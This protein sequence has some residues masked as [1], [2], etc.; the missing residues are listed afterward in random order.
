MSLT[1]GGWNALSQTAIRT[2]KT[3]Q[4]VRNV[5]ARM[6]KTS[7]D[8]KYEIAKVQIAQAIVMYKKTFGASPFVA[9]KAMGYEELP[10]REVFEAA[11][12]TED[13]I[14]P[15]RDALEKD[16]CITTGEYK[17]S[18]IMAMIA[19]KFNYPTK[20]PTIAESLATKAAIDV[21]VGN[22]FPGTAENPLE[23]TLV[24]HLLGAYL[25][26][27]MVSYLNANGETVSITFVSSFASRD[28][29]IAAIAHEKGHGWHAVILGDK[30]HGYS[31]SE[32]EQFAM[33]VEDSVA[34]ILGNTVSA[35]AP[36]FATAYG[37]YRQYVYGLVQAI[38]WD[39]LAKGTSVQDAIRA[40]KDAMAYYRID[41]GNGLIIDA[42]EFHNVGINIAI[43]AID[44]II[45]VVDSAI[46]QS[47]KKNGVAEVLVE[48]V[49]PAEALVTA[50]TV[51]EDAP[52]VEDEDELSLSDVMVKHFGPDWM[53][54]SEAKAM[55]VRA[56][57]A[58]NIAKRVEEL[59]DELK[60][61]RADEEA[62]STSE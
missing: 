44:G 42:T 39:E 40:A 14:A 10:W 48:A 9:L 5:L 58:E 24:P 7:L 52:E 28:Q 55:L 47:Q 17:L 53:G 51:V 30:W 43:E 34:H 57:G 25:R 27:T 26:P 20:A 16:L 56:A 4:V 59:I 45:Y 3:S 23:L 50:V 22:Y 46:A 38:V 15:L 8:T 2:Y 32:K 54:N 31:A 60:L 6:A 29:I 41:L 12:R 36:T 18:D 62:E 37:K 19:G 61:K 49:V 13:V 21:E 1:Q 33:A 11:V 35:T